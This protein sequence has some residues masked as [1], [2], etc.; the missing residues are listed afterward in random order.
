M[1]R[2]TTT[3]GAEVLAGPTSLKLRRASEVND[4][5]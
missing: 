4:L 3:F 5:D 1:A 2:T